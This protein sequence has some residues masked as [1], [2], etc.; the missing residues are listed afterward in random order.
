MQLLAVVDCG[1]YGTRVEPT[2][3]SRG[4]YG[5]SSPVQTF[6]AAGT[7]GARGTLQSNNAASV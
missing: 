1:T 3:L 5:K 2:N 6:T 4:V 7:R